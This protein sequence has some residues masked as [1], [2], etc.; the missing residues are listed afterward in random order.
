[1]VI[2][3]QT[4]NITEMITKQQQ[5]NTRRKTTSRQWRI[6]APRWRRENF[7]RQYINIITKPTAYD[8]SWEY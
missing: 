4:N 5:I 1:M 6:Q 8:G 3:R 2:D 7:F